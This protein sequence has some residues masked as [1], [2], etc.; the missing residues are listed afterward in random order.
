M[1]TRSTPVIRPATR[2]DIG[3][4]VRIEETCF[5]GDRISA[6]SFARLMARDSASI[7][8]AVTDGIVAGYALLLFRKNSKSARIYSLAVD[9]PHAGT[10]IARLLLEAVEAEGRRRSMHR[11]RLEVRTD[12]DRAVRMY[13]KLGFERVGR[14][15]RYYADGCDAIRYG[16]RLRGRGR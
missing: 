2:T 14:R 16:K 11:L 12:N 1:L 8:V 3:E 10:G 9:P 4:L 6:R 7:L 5:A 13:D 15:P